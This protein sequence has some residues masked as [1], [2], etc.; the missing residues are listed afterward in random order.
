MQLVEPEKFNC[1]VLCCVGDKQTYSSTN[2]HRQAAMQ[3]C[4]LGE[5]YGW[6]APTGQEGTFN[7]LAGGSGNRLS[8]NNTPLLHLHPQTATRAAVAVYKCTLT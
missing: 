3:V 8:I 1:P 5:L 4:V 6:L 2:T 7:T